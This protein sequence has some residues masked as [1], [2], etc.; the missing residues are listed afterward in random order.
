MSDFEQAFKYLMKNEQ[1]LEVDPNDAG[2]ITNY[3]ISLRF[4]K[5]LP[6][7]K[8]RTYGIFEEVSEQTIRDLRLDQAKSIYKGEFW[9]AAPFERLRN[10]DVCNYLFD[11]A[12]NMGV[13]PAIKCAQRACWSIMR[14][15]DLLDDGV[16]GDRTLAIFGLCGNLMMAAMRSERAGYYRLIEHIGNNAQFIKGWLTRAYESN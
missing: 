7:D 6:A 12:V 2:G 3:G 4:L 9:S 13:A 5:S 15:C 1:G 11:S 8:L 16:L 10:Q 14:K